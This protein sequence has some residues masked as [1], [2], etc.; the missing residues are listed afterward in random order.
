MDYRIRND[1]T[2]RWCILERDSHGITSPRDLTGKDL[3]V[4]VEL[5]GHTLIDIKDFTVS[6]SYVTFTWYGKDQPAPGPFRLILTENA[7]QAGMRQLDCTPPDAFALVRYNSD[8]RPGRMPENV[9]DLTTDLTSVISVVAENAIPDTI[10]R[11]AWVNGQL[12]HYYT[13]A[14][15]DT[16]L[17]D[18]V[19]KVAGK[20]LSAND[21]TDALLSKLNDIASGAQVNII[22]GVQ[23]NGTDLA[24]TDK[25]VNV[26]VPTALADLS[27][28]TT[29]RL[30]T[31]TEKSNWGAKYDKP[32]DGIPKSD[33]ASGVQTSLGKADSALQEHQ[34][35]AAYVNG[36]SYNS[37]SKKIELKH[38]SAVLAEID[39]TAFIKDGMVS[40][41]RITGGNLVISF[42]TDAG[43]EDIS[44]AL[45][46]IFNPAN[47]YDKTAADSLLAG[48]QDTIPDLDEIRAGAA[49]G[50]TSIQDIS[51]LAEQDGS[52]DA[53]TVGAARN[54]VGAE[55]SHAEFTYRTTGG[56]A[57]VGTG[58]AVIEKI[59]GLTRKVGSALLHNIATALRAI[60]YNRYNPVTG[61]A[62]LLAGIKTQVCGTFTSLNIDG[63]A[64]TLDAGGYFTPAE[65]CELTVVGGNAV[66]TDVHFSWSGYRDYGQADYLWEPYTEST[67]ELDIASAF[68]TG[69]KSIGDACDE[70][71]ETASLRRIGS[72]DLG[73]L[74]WTYADG[75]FSASVTGKA[76]GVSNLLCGPYAVGSGS[77]SLAN[78]Q[79]CGDA[80]TATVYLRDDSHLIA[81]EEGEGEESETT[82][83]GDIAGLKAALDGKALVFVLATPVSETLA[84]PLSLS[85]P[86]DDF[87]SEER[88][89]ANSVPLVCD[90]R[91]A[92]NARDILRKLPDTYVAKDEIVQTTGT[93]EDAVM[94]QK[95][96]T[97]ALQGLAAGT[98]L[99]LLDVEFPR[100]ETFET[101]IE[102]EY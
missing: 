64:V 48:K 63:T 35:L 52:Y 10:A 82:Y 88:V 4:Q 7:G 14:Q 32:A 95:A 42:N 29:H 70:L 62:Y 18:K 36:G 54:I 9:D 17:A 26:T 65:D 102:T 85:Y 87:G 25:K 1:R 80:S 3:T 91:Y 38:D 23:V 31:D 81:H 15:L 97:E 69:M 72:V 44:I 93:A 56:S 94:S 49:L 37:V 89:S 12:A 76:A 47:Y 67:L 78:G 27:E 60:G 8:I 84:E 57:D 77:G 51:N 20:G 53:M 75:I 22:E 45:T 58:A 101:L 50:A 43:K 24:I 83:T 79:I 71:T 11:V 98:P 13:S 46:D 90:I 28:D 41:V 19:D 30:V 86:A 5:N 16:L 74:D 68:P 92:L 34:S 73:S 100:D 66:D 40:N 99:V 96:V 61:K 6:E 39:A 33:L 59:Y 21:F 55:V 2:F